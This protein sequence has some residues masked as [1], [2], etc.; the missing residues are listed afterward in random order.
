[1]IVLFLMAVG[2]SVCFRISHQ[3]NSKRGELQE[4]GLRK[5]TAAAERHKIMVAFQFT[6]PQHTH[7]GRRSSC[8]IFYPNKALG[9]A[10]PNCQRLKASCLRFTRTPLSL[11]TSAWGSHCLQWFVPKPKIA[12]KT[13]RQKRNK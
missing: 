10:A 6:C 2:W 4:K 12:R 11:A 13:I 5:G 9:K 3:R 7:A 1:M 8:K